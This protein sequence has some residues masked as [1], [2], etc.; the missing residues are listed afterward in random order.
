MYLAG[1]PGLSKMSVSNEL[2]KTLVL[3]RTDRKGISLKRNQKNN[4]LIHQPNENDQCIISDDLVERSRTK[5]SFEKGQINEAYHHFRHSLDERYML[6]RNGG[7]DLCVYD[8][9][10]MEKVETYE[11]FWEMEGGEK[12]RQPASVTAQ[13][14]GGQKLKP[15]E[16]A[17]GLLDWNGR[18]QP[19]WLWPPAG[20]RTQS[21]TWWAPWTGM[22]RQQPCHTKN[23]R[24]GQSGGTGAAD[25]GRGLGKAGEFK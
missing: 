19:P 8:V 23:L 4:M 25:Q 14:V 18:P 22:A 1:G 15:D 20:R 6:W 16:T 5:G 2:L 13:N 21:C 24:G 9:E 7:R 17:A 12:A 10:K 11:N 3:N